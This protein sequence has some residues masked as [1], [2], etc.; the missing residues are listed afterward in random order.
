[1]YIIWLTQSL[2]IKLSG[3]GDSLPRSVYRLGSQIDPCLDWKIIWFWRVHNP[4]REDTCVCVCVFQVYFYIK[5]SLKLTACTWECTLLEGTSSYFSKKSNLA[6]WTI[7]FIWPAL[8][9]VKLTT[10]PS[11]E[12]DPP[13]YPK[14]TLKT[15]LRYTWAPTRPPGGLPFR[16][17]FWCCLSCCVGSL[18]ALRWIP[19][20]Q[21]L[22]NLEIC[23]VFL[24]IFWKLA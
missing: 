7:I 4:K 15:N 22:G 3:L 16:W 13:G 20:R 12:I 14:G 23:C 24:L 21:R 5:P 2:T 8:K 1:M 9:L 18:R 10:P 17:F 11:R 19:A 6:W